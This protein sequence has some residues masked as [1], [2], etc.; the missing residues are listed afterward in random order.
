MNSINA[1]HGRYASVNPIPAT[2]WNIVDDAELVARFERWFSMHSAA[3]R[4]HALTDA[5]ALRDAWMEMHR[6][7]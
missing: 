2:R 7:G 1:K 6:E 5:R 3:K 4:H